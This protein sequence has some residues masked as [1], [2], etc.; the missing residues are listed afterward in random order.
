MVRH[1]FLDHRRH[2][3]RN[4]SEERLVS[5]GRWSGSIAL[6]IGVLFAPM[7]MRW[8]SL[9]RYA[10]DIW[11]PM[12]A[13]VVVVFLTAALWKNAS[14]RDALACLWL[15]ILTVP[16]SLTT[17]FLADAGIEFMPKNLANSM[18]F[19]GSISLVSWCLMGALTDRR[20]LW[21]G[22]A[23]ALVASILIFWLAAHS[24]VL[25][26]VLMCAAMAVFVGVPAA[27][28][29]R[30][31]SGMWDFS[32]LSSGHEAGWYANLWL[33]WSLCAAVFVAIYIY[34]W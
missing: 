1:R 2:W 9:F 11:A 26:T 14:Q 18:V 25:M 8:D 10:Q 13:P 33:W 4:W 24:P 21:L 30:R 6:L 28:R 16:F 23:Y 7:V 17:A 32:M 31:I 29:S 27:M 19:A 5:F 3:G 34:F 20:P 22:L 12:A 15:A